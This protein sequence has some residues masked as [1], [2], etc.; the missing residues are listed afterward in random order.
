MRWFP[1]AIALS[2]SVAPAQTQPDLKFNLASIKANSNPAGPRWQ[3]LPG[4]R[5]QATATLESLVTHAFG[6]NELQLSGVRGW[7]GS[8]TFDIDA[9]AEGAPQKLREEQFQRMLQALLVE[10][11]ALKFHKESRE[12]SVYA[13]TIGPKGTKL[14]PIGAERPVMPPSVPGKSRLV[15]LSLSSLARA[16]SST[17]GRLVLD[18]TK[19]TGDYV[20]VLDYSVNGGTQDD[21][22]SAMMDAVQEQL[23]L[24]LVPR[25]TP[26]DIIVIDHAERPTVR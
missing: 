10:R 17:S 16:L 2:L 24:K 12:I 22:A 3:L 6:I 20:I 25:K 23:G 1:L 19:L 15:A 21:M 11:F 26:V 9:K 5:F 4:G 8:E 7:I 14:K 13:L 18:E